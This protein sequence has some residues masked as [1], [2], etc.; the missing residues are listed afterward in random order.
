MDYRL[1]LN[2]PFLAGKSSEHLW[3]SSDIM[4]PLRKILA[5]LR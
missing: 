1:F 3:T 4:G 5:L 2:F